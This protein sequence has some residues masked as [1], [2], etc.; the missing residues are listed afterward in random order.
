MKHTPGKW[1]VRKNPENFDEVEKE[2]SIFKENSFIQVASVS[3]VSINNPK[4]HEANARLIASTPELLEACYRMKNY[5]IKEGHAKLDSETY[6]FYHQI[7]Q[8][9]AKAEGKE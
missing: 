4:E 8:A 5:L 7:E 2:Y 1:E 3:N 6:T 9:I